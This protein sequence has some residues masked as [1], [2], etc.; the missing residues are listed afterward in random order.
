MPCACG[1]VLTE[2]G[3]SPASYTA[4][5]PCASPHVYCAEE[6]QRGSGCC[7][8]TVCGCRCGPPHPLDLALGASPVPQLPSPAPTCWAC[9][10]PLPLSVTSRH[11]GRP[12]SP[13]AVVLQRRFS[14][15]PRGSGWRHRVAVRVW[16]RLRVA[17]APAS[18]GALLRCC[19][20]L[21]GHGR[22]RRRPVQYWPL[23]LATL[24]ADI[25]RV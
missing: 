14:A 9:A 21:S 11:G 24:A 7:S 1:C 22:A 8:K 19:L 25:E 2:C 23:I 16:S 17:V 3:H 15:P 5:L 4:A 18:G 6:K 12:S 10:A 13:R 20:C